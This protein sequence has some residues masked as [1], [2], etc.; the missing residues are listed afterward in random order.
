MKDFFRILL[1]CT[2][3]LLSACI[4]D[5]TEPEVPYNPA[6]PV[7]FVTT[8]ISTRGAIVDTLSEMTTMGVFCSWTNTTDWTSSATLGKMFNQKLNYTAGEW[9]YPAGQDVY[10]GAT[11]LA[12]RFTFFAYAPFGSG[13]Y[14]ASSNPSGNGLTVNGSTSSTGIPT[15]TYT[16]PT[17]V[18]NQPDLM[19]AVPNKNMRPT[20]K[21]V[22]LEMNHALTC[23]A[24]QIAGDGDKVTG[25]AITGVSVK[26]NLAVDGE[27]VTWSGLEAATTTDFSAS[28]N[29]DAG[30]TYYTTSETM[31][32]NLIAGNGYL[33]MIPQTL[34]SDAKVVVTMSDGSTKELALGTA[35]WTAGQRITYNITIKTDLEGGQADILYFDT[36]DNNRLKIGRWGVDVTSISNMVFTQFGG[37]IGFTGVGSWNNTTSIKFNP[38]STASYAYTAINNY[39]KPTTAWAG[40]A[41]PLVSDPAYHNDANLLLGRGDICKLVGLTSAEAQ[42]RV[43]ANSLDDY[44]SGWR[45]PTNEENYVFIGVAPDNT[46]SSFNTS[47]GYYTWTGNGSNASNPGTGSFPK[48][49]YYQAGVNAVTLPAAGRRQP[50]GSVLY[51]GTSGY[52]CSSTAY[53]SSSDYYLNINSSGVS[54]SSTS[55][56]VFGFS[57]RCISTGETPTPPTITVSPTTATFAAAGE[58]KTFTV[59]TTNYSGSIDV[60]LTD[61]TSSWLTY[62]LNGS[63]LS[64]T[65][66]A[67]TGA[68]RTST[69]TLTAGTATTKLIVSQDGIVL[70]GG[71]ADILYFDTNDNNRLK[72]GR[73]GSDITSVTN[74]VHTQFGS[75]IGFTGFGDWDNTNSI[76]FNPTSTASYDYQSIPNYNAWNATEEKS[77]LVS[78]TAYHNGTNIKAGR[79]DICKLVGL[80]SAQAQAMSAAELDA[81]QSGWRLPSLQENRVFVGI[82]ANDDTSTFNTSSGYFTWT[83]NG[84]TTS[85]PGTATFPKNKYAP[86]VTLPAVDGRDGNGKE[87]YQGA[88]GHYWTSSPQNQSYGY[89]MYFNHNYAYLPYPVSNIQGYV[90]RCVPTG[91]TPTPPPTSPTITVSPTTATFAA[92]GE[93]K[94]FTVTTTNYSGSVDVSL[95]DGTSSWLTYTLNGTTLSLTAAANTGAERT[96]TVTLTAGSATTKLIVSQDARP[97]TALAPPGVIGYIKGTNTLTLNGSRE[98]ANNNAIKQY[99]IDTFGGLSDSTVYVA[100]FKYGSLIALSS[101]PAD[102]TPDA[103][104]KYLQ[105]DDVIAGPSEWSDYAAFKANPVW[106]DIPYYTANVTAVLDPADAMGDPCIYYFGQQWSTPSSYMDTDTSY[107]YDSSNFKWYD[108]DGLGAD[109]SAGRLSTRAGETGVYY[110][111]AGH[112]HSYGRIMSLGDQGSYWTTKIHSGPNADILYFTNSEIPDGTA[113]E[114]YLGLAI[115]CV[116]N[117]ITVNVNPD[118]ISVSSGTSNGH[119][120]TVTTNNTGG[121]TATTFTSWITLTNPSGPNYSGQNVVFNVTEANPTTSPRTGT[122]TVTGGTGSPSTTITVTQAAGGLSAPEPELSIDVSQG[123]DIFAWKGETK[124]FAVTATNLTETPTITQ[125]DGTSSWLHPSL[126]DAAL[127]IQADANYSTTTTRSATITL[128]AGALSATVPVTQNLY[129]VQQ[130]PDGGVIAPPGVIGYIKGTNTLTLRGSKEYSSNPAIAAY[131]Q[132]IDSR[133]LEDSTVYVAYFKF[134][135][136][137]AISSDPNDTEEPYLEGND[138]V[139]APSIADGYI[140][141]ADLQMYVDARSNT[142]NGW[143]IIPLDDRAGQSGKPI[144]TDLTRAKGDACDYWFGDGDGD[145]FGDGS[146]WCLPTGPTRT[147][148]NVV[149]EPNLIWFEANELGEGVP[150][151]RLS[152]NSGETGVFYPLTGD[153]HF[154]PGGQTSQQHSEGGYWSSYFFWNGSNSGAYLSVY[155]RASTTGSYWTYAYSYRNGYAVRCVKAGLSAPE[156]PKQPSIS[157]SPNTAIFAAEGETKQFTVTTNLS[158]TPTV[159]KTGDSSDTTAAWITSASIS[160]TTLTITTAANTSATAR[161]ARIT[162]TIDLAIAIVNVT[163]NS[164]DGGQADI[165]YFDTNDNNRL[166]IGRWGVDVT[167]ISNMVFTQFGSVIGFTANDSWSND[168]ILFNPTATAS[169][170]YTL[171]PNYGQPTTAWAG[172]VAASALVSDPEY[173]NDANLA[174]GR[175]DICKLVGLT[176]AEA[177]AKVVAGTLDDYESG[178]RLPT[179]KENRV[180]IGIAEDD[181]TS[182]FDTSSGVFT[183]TTKD[184][185]ASNPDTATFPQNKYY[186][187]GVN[188]VTLPVAGGRAQ[189]DGSLFLNNSDVGF[190]WSS[191]LYSDTLGQG[192]CISKEG[193]YPSS[194]YNYASGYA[195]RCVRN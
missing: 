150:A 78:S 123:A 64:L 45:L 89:S 11:S 175:G 8:D 187:V 127:T 57:V 102:Q 139:A 70:E 17:K 162:I 58:T 40:A 144:I 108:L 115:R 146:T 48:N 10:W 172:S 61:G 148:V 142:Q 186:E 131:A 25:I 169:Y 132:T 149:P 76:L 183:Y 79:G 38:T 157:V 129:K 28:L 158:G 19:V 117:T 87:S 151:G 145:G 173:H 109:I 156:E 37:V 182:E 29:Y 69:V 193:V 138:I 180:F 99:A 191:T 126:S 122:I 53:R 51:Q 12:E 96:S 41:S 9:E 105:S 177:Q 65:A 178:W 77:P 13:A 125:T 194:Y 50:D 188:D 55:S 82:A 72:I 36:S 91:E 168:D 80:T 52:Y 104:G 54:P 93:T 110:P 171:I 71:Q 121:W 152:T 83:E 75:V 67:N 116:P 184:G 44:D 39:G 106:D 59:T 101:D 97:I 84:G 7:R 74:I 154:P 62:T 119:T 147:N 22:S 33:M 118:T 94:Q 98:Y 140:G 63:T 181:T 34:T 35:T 141:L 31:S 24:F 20:G 143:S 192:M 14:D 60:S 6:S 161:S 5:V 190:F 26:G 16:V 189:S 167:S 166:K 112:R 128:T 81:Y 56:Y 134:G 23:V 21:P 165:L 95:T 18:E 85:T 90:S 185:N 49:K 159:T 86:G 107:M 179:L 174:S 170:Y 153:R 114:I 133:G 30:Q 66:A 111:A 135:S 88:I 4:V 68:E 195:I 1:L 137:V 124:T 164:V 92:A 120:S 32:T 15:L 47:S 163:Q 113:G 176:S 136:L 100:Y 46:T 27:T 43:N 130:P 3:A 103:N 155:G 42:A 2:I 160:G 73:W